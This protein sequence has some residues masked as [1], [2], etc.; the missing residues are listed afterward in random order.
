MMGTAHSRRFQGIPALPFLASLCPLRRIR[1]KGGRLWSWVAQGPTLP[2]NPSVSCLPHLLLG[3]RTR[4]FPLPVLLHPLQGPQTGLTCPPA[5]GSVTPANDAHPTLV[6]LT[7]YAALSTQGR[8]LNVMPQA[9]SDQH[10][11]QRGWRPPSFSTVVPPFTQPGS[12]R[13]RQV[14]L[15]RA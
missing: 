4:S 14:L 13:P 10:R 11:G 7:V 9:C 15:I 8:A 3:H 1:V 12:S 2:S 6:P 5:T